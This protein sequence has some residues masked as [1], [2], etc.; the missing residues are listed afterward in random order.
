MVRVFYLG[1]ISRFP[2][3]SFLLFWT[4]SAIE[5]QFHKNKKKGFPLQ[6]GLK[7]NCIFNDNNNIND[8][9]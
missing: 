7:N 1:A 2:L 4:F 8:N 3:Q 9:V 6:S 5:K